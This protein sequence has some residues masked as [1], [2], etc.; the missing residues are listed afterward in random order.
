MGLYN[1]LYEGISL[2]SKIGTEVDFF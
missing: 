1:T 2:K